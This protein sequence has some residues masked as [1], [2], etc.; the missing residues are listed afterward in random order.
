MD[1][2]IYL[3]CVGVATIAH[4]STPWFFLDSAVKLT[5]WYSL[6]AVALVC[7]VVLA[8]S[9]HAYFKTETGDD[10]TG[11]GTAILAVNVLP[12]SLISFGAALVTSLVRLAANKGKKES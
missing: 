4:I 2:D 10:G 3:A 7:F 6:S 8:L 12:L 5:I 1:P 9:V 11:I